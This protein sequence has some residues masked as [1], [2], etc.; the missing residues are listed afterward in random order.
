MGDINMIPADRLAKKHQ[1]A[2]LRLWTLVCGVYF[3]CLAVLVLSGRFFCSGVNDP[4]TEEIKSTAER[5]ESYSST[6]QRLQEKL[7]KA[8]VELQACQAISCRP[9]W[10]KLLVLLSSELGEEVVLGN[11]QIVILNK[12]RNVKDNLRELFSSS[13]PAA[14]LA[15]RRYKLELS[16]YGRTQTAVSQFVLRLE[17]MR[18]FDSVRLINSYRGA[19]LN[20]EAVAFSIECSI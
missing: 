6:I 8:T 1:K 10:S 13:D 4:I 16:G 5:I 9:D 19:F 3:I 17:R 12:G 2:R 15:D 20:N 18:I 7:A 11:C 14:L